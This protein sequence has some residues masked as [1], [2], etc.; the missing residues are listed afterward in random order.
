MCLV[1]EVKD[2]SLYAFQEE[3]E[4]ELEHNARF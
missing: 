3:S 1:D 4:A 2:L